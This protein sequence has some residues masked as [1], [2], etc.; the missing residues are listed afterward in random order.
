M[1]FNKLA[2]ITFLFLA[3]ATIAIADNGCGTAVGNVIMGKAVLQ[4]QQITGNATL[5]D[6]TITG[7]L[8]VLGGVT[9][10][11]AKL[12]SLDVT[13][14]L[15]LMNTVVS[16]PVTVT[17]L[18]VASNSTF[19]D[20]LVHGDSLQLEASTTGNIVIDSS[21]TNST[22]TV[23]LAKKCTVNGNITFTKTAGVVEMNDS[24]ITGQIIGGKAK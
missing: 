12:D 14:N 13:G 15:S 7:K 17:G 4:C 9:A 20:I 5:T 11:G 3:N 21:R 23:Q 8:S 16:G 1:K 24:K 2:V 22:P 19:K 10:T 6:T 18:F